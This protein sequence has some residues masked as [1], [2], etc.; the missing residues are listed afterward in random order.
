MP[1]KPQSRA[2]DLAYGAALALVTLIMTDIAWQ[3]RSVSVNQAGIVKSLAV[4]IAVA[5]GFMEEGS[6]FTSADGLILKQRVEAL[7][8][9]ITEGSLEIRQLNRGV[10]RLEDEVFRNKPK[11][12]LPRAR[13]PAGSDIVNHY[14]LTEIGIIP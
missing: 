1:E 7:S 6:R 13:G 2:K 10:E 3:M 8:E 9:E 12:A 5:D 14:P 4:H 11:P